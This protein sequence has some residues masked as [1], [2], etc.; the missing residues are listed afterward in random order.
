MGKIITRLALSAAAASMAI[1]PIAAQANTRA[2]SSGT[3][4]SSSVSQPGTG[5]SV[6]GEEIAGIP[7]IL[8]IVFAAAT[9]AGIVII[10]EDDDDDDDDDNQSPGAN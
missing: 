8:A 1:A 6:D 10:A 9:I 5:R 4:Y 2:G 3:F 7:A